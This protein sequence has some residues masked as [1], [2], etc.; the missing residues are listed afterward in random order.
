V[1]YGTYYA[2]LIVGS[3]W[4]ADAR[5]DLDLPHVFILSYADGAGEASVDGT[6][7]ALD[8][9]PSS[10]DITSIALGGEAYGGTPAYPCTGHIYAVALCR[11]PVIGADA[12]AAMAAEFV[13]RYLPPR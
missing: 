8:N 12:H 7:V 13:R 1:G 3:G 6:V 11:R 5:D 9:L 10:G 2:N 4:S